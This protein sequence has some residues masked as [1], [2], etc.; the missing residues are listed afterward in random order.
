[1]PP[2]LASRVHK[3]LCIF[4]TVIGKCTEDRFESVSIQGGS[5]CWETFGLPNKRNERVRTTEPPCWYIIHL[6]GKSLDFSAWRHQGKD[7][8]A[9]SWSE[10]PSRAA[11]SLLPR[12]VNPAVDRVETRLSSVFQKVLWKREIRLLDTSVPG[13]NPYPNNSAP[14]FGRAREI[15][16]NIRSCAFQNQLSEPARGLSRWET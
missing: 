1:M 13:R 11:G 5:N 16:C 14:S 7:K 12:P 2:C 4:A 10:C 15:L 6:F 3:P 8:E 9:L